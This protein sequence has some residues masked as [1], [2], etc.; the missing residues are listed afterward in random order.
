MD[1]GL[2][3]PRQPRSPAAPTAGGDG[4]GGGP[5]PPPPPPPPPGRTPSA[6]LL[7]AARRRHRP[8]RRGPAGGTGGGTPPPPPRRP[9]EERDLRRD[10]CPRGAPPPPLTDS[11]CGRWGCG[12]SRLLGVAAPGHRTGRPHGLR[13][14]AQLPGSAVEGKAGGSFLETPRRCGRAWLRCPRPGPAPGPGAATCF[15]PKKKKKKS[16]FRRFGQLRGS[17]FGKPSKGQA[18]VEG[19][20][21]GTSGRGREA[22]R[23]PASTRP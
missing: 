12:G 20:G 5:A 3:R 1:G 19:D 9:V 8:P 14:A 11:P 22:G 13:G 17:L 6:A 2:R 15:F 16:V 23:V 10:G 18:Q 21:L 4:A 7:Q